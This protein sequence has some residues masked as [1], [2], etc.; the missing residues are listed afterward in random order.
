MDAR[1]HIEKF[2]PANYFITKSM[3]LSRVQTSG[4]LWFTKKFLVYYYY[5]FLSDNIR[6]RDDAAMI[7]NI[8]DDYIASMP[9]AVQKDAEMFF[10]SAHAVA[11]PKSPEFRFFPEFAGSRIFTSH[12]ERS[13]YM[14]LAKKYYFAFLMETGG[15][16]GVNDFIKERIYGKDFDF[17][18]T[19]EII[20]E[21]YGGTAFD[22]RQKL[23]DY[24]ASL[25]NERQV[26]YYYGFFHSK[27]NGA[28]DEEFSSLTPVGE[29]ALCSNFY[30][31]I[32]I[33]EHQKFKM[34]SQPVSL[35]LDGKYL[36]GKHYDP[37]DFTVNRDPYLTILSW[38]ESKGGF[39]MDE[40]QYI[41]SRLPA[42]LF[43]VSEID[44]FR[45][46][47][48]D[49]RK[50]VESFGR[51]SEIK[52]E[53]FRKELLK[54]ILGLRGDLKKDRSSNPMSVCRLSGRNVIVTDMP[55]LRLV[56]GYY[57]LLSAYK[58]MRYGHLFDDCEA[59]L[60][61]QYAER[62]QGRSYEIDRKIKIDWDLYNIHVD[63]PVM[64]TSMLLVAAAAKLVDPDK[65]DYAGAASV[66]GTMMPNIMKHCGFSS[67]TSM[68]KAVERL[69]NAFESGDFYA[70]ASNEHEEYSIP[71]F[72]Y[73]FESN[74]DIKAKL[75]HESMMPSLYR[76]GRR[77]RNQNVVALL[78]AYNSTL[79]AGNDGLCECC[80]GSTF[81]TV[82]NEPYL[83]YHHLIPFGMYEGPD[84]YLNLFALCPMCHRKLHFLPVKD[85]RALYEDLSGHNY[86]KI[87]LMHRLIELKKAKRLRSYHL[88]FLLADNAITLDEYEKITAA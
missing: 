24:M 87:P 45:E 52:T 8:F 61:R 20:S 72:E 74:A 27:S 17:S 83:E 84:H 41:I 60:R 39:S 16:A 12:E 77:V 10:Y 54:Y 23:N 13:R 14:A 40:Y 34:V 9:E 50:H 64:M 58:S 15:Q 75:E 69:S 32:A 65:A 35:H 70:Y 67:K 71:V 19:E 1:S 36:K 57:K 88:D 22:L 49:A 81:R 26:L 37:E 79:P 30:E 6:Y 47:I 68:K 21:Y 4:T 55:L 29:L 73:K 82:Q 38:M 31:L 86:R 48:D 80:G 66:L 78:K 62:E 28:S 3:D 46:H 76:D 25:R 85:K 59:E 18:Q 33:W 63:I 43:D 51:R 53:D 56:I 2:V 7:C 11:N 42:P 44:D 5:I